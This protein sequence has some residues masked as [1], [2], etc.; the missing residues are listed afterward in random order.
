MVN[1]TLSVS[2]GSLSPPLGSLVCHVSFLGVV[3]IQNGGRGKPD[4]WSILAKLLGIQN[5]LI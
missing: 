1:V 3:S 4:D 2:K 5:K